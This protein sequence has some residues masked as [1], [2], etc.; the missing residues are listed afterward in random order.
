MQR[1]LTYPN[2]VAKERKLTFPIKLRCTS[3]EDLRNEPALEEALARALGRAFAKAQTALPLALAT[4]AGVLLKTPHLTS[5]P[6]AGM[7]AASLLGLVSRAVMRAA[8]ARS[9]PLVPSVRPRLRVGGRPAVAQ[10]PHVF[11]RFDDARLD[12]DTGTYD[13]PSYDGGRTSTPTE[14][15][16]ARTLWHVLRKARLRLSLDSFIDWRIALDPGKPSA[17]DKTPYLDI[18][19]TQRAAIAWL[20]TADAVWSADDLAQEVLLR[21]ADDVPFGQDVLYGYSIFESARETLANLVS[22]HP[23]EGFGP[24]RPGRR[25]IGGGDWLLRGSLMLFVGMAV[26]NTAISTLATLGTDLTC[27][28]R[29]RDLDFLID[30]DNFGPAFGVTWDNYKSQFGDKPVTVDI[31]PIYPNSA[32]HYKTLRLRAEDYAAAHTA[33]DTV[34]FGQLRLLTQATLDAMP[35]AL[36]SQLNPLSGPETKALD[37]ANR[38]GVWDPD[39]AGAYIYVKL[40][41]TADELAVARQR[42][43]ALRVLPQI[44]NWIKQDPTDYDWAK[45]FHRFLRNTF[46]DRPPDKRPDDGTVFEFVLAELEKMGLFD[47]LFDD[48]ERAFEGRGA[49]QLTLQLALA[50]RYATHPRVQKSQAMLGA[51]TIEELEN[52]YRVRPQAGAPAVLLDHRDDLVVGARDGF[53][54]VDS[55]YIFEHDNKRMKAAVQTRLKAEIRTQ[56]QA[57][58]GEILHDPG[59]KQYSEDAFA[60]EVLCRAVRKIGLTNDDFEKIT[61]QRSLMLL[62]VTLKTVEAR[63]RYFI[64]FQPAERVK[65]EGGAWEPVGPPKTEIDDDFEARLIYWQLGRAG[66]FWSAAGLVVS[67]VALI[68]VAWE[69]GAI[70]FLVDLAGGT[71]TVLVSIGISELLYIYRVIFKGEEFSFRG[72]MVAALD[73]YLGA[74]GFRG[75]GAVGARLT[76]T[77]GRESMQKLVAGWVAEKFVVGALGGAGTAALTKFSHDLINIASG[78]GTWSPIGTYVSNMAIGA[79]FGLAIEFVGAP[80]IKSLGGRALEQINDARDLARLLRQEGLSAARLGRELTEGLAGLKAHLKEVM[81]DVGANGFIQA[82]S[83]RLAGVLDEMGARFVSNRVL[84]LAEASLTNTGRSGLEKLLAAT[85]QRHGRADLL[86]KTLGNNPAEAN[87]FLEAANT[88]DAA[89]IRRLLNGFEGEGAQLSTFLARI[90][91]LTGPERDSILRVLL[92]AEDGAS[93]SSRSTQAALQRQLESS[94]AST[95]T[96]PSPPA[97]ASVETAADPAA[98]YLDAVRREPP[99][100]GT[101]GRRWDYRRFPRAPRGARWRPGD[102]IDMPGRDGYPTFGT[103]RG[104]YWSNRAHFE[105]EARSAG[106]ARRLPDSQDPIQRLS[107]ADLVAIRDSG[108]AP[109]APNLPG[110]TMELEHIGVPQRIRNWLE[111]LGFKAEEARRLTEV[112]NPAALLEV[113]PPEHAFFDAE[114]WGFGERRADAAG[115]RWSG[116][117]AADPRVTRPLIDMSDDTILEIERLARGRNYDFTANP[118]ARSIRAALEAEIRARNLTVPGGPP[119]PPSGST[120]GTPPPTGGGAPPPGGG[121]TPPPAD[122]TPGPSG[123][124]IPPTPPPP[125]VPVSPNMNISPQTA[126][127]GGITGLSGFR[128]QDGS[129]QISVQGRVLPSI[130]RQGF[131][132]G[133]VRGSDLGLANYDLLHL[134]GPRLGDEAAAGIWLGPTPIN[135]GVQARIEA[136]LEGLA[137]V[138]DSQHGSLN[139]RVTGSTHPRAELPA[140]L[141]AHDFLA[142]VKYEFTVEIPGT[143]S[144]SGRVIIRIGTPPNGRIE[145]LGAASLDRLTRAA[146]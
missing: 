10:P 127:T 136:Q 40:K 41:L 100:V 118:G 2:G 12:L 80:V 99:A 126:G 21:F 87:A 58:I 9:L 90:G 66:E 25:L 7:D 1:A 105:L 79:V 84:A 33:R 133:L 29:A 49:W 94:A 76:A 92:E 65:G 142:E 46:G 32:I 135:I 143:P 71:T 83:S 77:I 47:T 103:A 5:P 11:E 138:A 50:T 67:G 27:G 81:N 144:M 114:A 137:A 122:G 42:P 123:G 86:F 125:I 26:P 75:A 128:A 107:D 116:T 55:I 110:R 98:A 130:A 36:R 102:P 146:R 82:A 85:E 52:A 22:G 68:A 124:G 64:T 73:G 16:K 18:L 51:L 117:Q 145:L 54:D 132:H 60:K 141:R 69:A 108:R 120:G 57:L 6:P 74:V 24:L 8:A 34:F 35:A 15:R 72:L 45:G 28:L 31:L 96:P 129:M 37:E 109:P 13:I 91:R 14:H 23:L 140:N 38:F 3:P 56:A 112:S 63:P 78:D 93:A 20:V 134:W 61:I 113:T 17:D 19:P 30:D 53:G 106:T 62:D 89:T 121:G 95:T 119:P 39:W 44:V 115:Q 104:R 4:G 48:V 59:T 131:E 111:A 97:A 101:A 70:A 43:A 139:L 88:L